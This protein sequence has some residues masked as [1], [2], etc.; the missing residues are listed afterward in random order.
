MNLAFPI[1]DSALTNAIGHAAGAFLFGTFL[2]LAFPRHRSDNKG[3]ALLAAGLALLWNVV[4]LNVLLLSP[5]QGR[6]AEVL[7]AVGFS[8]LSLLP[9]VLLQLCLRGSLSWVVRA[10]YGLGAFALACHLGELALNVPDLHKIGLSAITFGFGALTAFS[11]LRVL[12]TTQEST[13]GTTSRTMAV[14]SLFLLAVSFAHLNHGHIEEAWSQE[15]LLHH[16]GIPLAL[17]VLL[18]D[19]RFV[20]A[21]ALI[22]L[23]ANVLLA[24]LFGWCAVAVSSG[25]SLLV[26]VAAT[27]ALVGGFGFARQ[28]A[29]RMLTKL[30]FRQPDHQ[31]LDAILG[32]FQTFHGDEPE[33]LEKAAEAM[34]ERMG[35]ELLGIEKLPANMNDLI[36]AVPLEEAVGG[37][38]WKRRGTALVVP[39]RVPGSDSHVV[40]LGDRRGGRPYLSLDL[41]FLSLLAA[42]AAQ[43][44]E[45]IRALETE[46]LVSQAELRALQAQ[47]HPHFLF[48][49]LN[50]LYGIIPREATAARKTVLNLADIFRYFLRTETAFVP[51]KEELHV[52]NAYLA[53]EAH[54]L[55]NKLAI[56]MVIDDSLLGEPV[57]VLSIEP[58]VENAIKHGVGRRPEGGIVRIEIAR[59]EEG[60]MRVMVSDTGPGFEKAT[61]T[62]ALSGAGVGL[63]NVSRRLE[64]CYGPESELSVE[65]TSRGTSVAFHIPCRKRDANNPTR[66]STTTV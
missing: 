34:A 15:L 30:A 49:A 43:Q 44:L 21:D 22:R 10:G 2:V 61:T 65:S 57:P 56:E 4:S 54:R 46:R 36:S 9:A 17:F 64:L 14:M 51:L 48:N 29:Q 25:R 28:L 42:G 11:V 38:K 39:I 13:R 52:V 18:Q 12:W 60:R 23:F 50:T 7:A 40:L 55:G 47:I 26:Q 16:A 37:P 24:V 58:L 8:T 19:Y 6:L 3:L 45:R 27:S 35:A 41:E 62:A 32:T 5:Q 63:A 31:Q 53:I 20:F 66:T 1:P 33:F 59:A